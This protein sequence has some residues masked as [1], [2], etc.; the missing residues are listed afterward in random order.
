M[1]S[2]VNPNFLASLNLLRSAFI[3]EL[4]LL[5]S[6]IRSDSKTRYLS[7]KMTKLWYLAEFLNH[8]SEKWMLL[9]IVVM[10][11][12]SLKTINLTKNKKWRLKFSHLAQMRTN[13]GNQTCMIALLFFKKLQIILLK[14]ETIHLAYLQTTTHE[15]RI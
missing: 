12:M 13:L 3:T 14:S 10:T 9:L 11:I 15:K 2:K 1:I 5:L 6:T 7:Q 4:R 8:I